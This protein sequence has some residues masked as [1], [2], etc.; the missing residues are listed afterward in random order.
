MRARMNGVAHRIAAFAVTLIF[1]PA[2]AFV[3][4]AL[5]SALT[6]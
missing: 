2:V 4:N 6:G 3:V 1:L 5:W